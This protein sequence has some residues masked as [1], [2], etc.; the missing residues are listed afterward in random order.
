LPA[1]PEDDDPLARFHALLESLAACPIGP[2]GH[3]ASLLD[4]LAERDPALLRPQATYAAWAA[5]DPDERAGSETRARTALLALLIG[6]LTWFGL[7]GRVSESA[8]QQAVFLTPLGVVSSP[9]STWRSPPSPLPPSP[10]SWGGRG[11]QRV[12]RVDRIAHVK[13]KT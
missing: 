6:P 12:F 7:L 8:N 10:P 3:P 13:R 9:A 2:L 11:S 4:S 5:L 1:L